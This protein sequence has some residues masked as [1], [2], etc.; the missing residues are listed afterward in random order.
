MKNI[1]T[2]CIALFI[3]AGSLYAQSSKTELISKKWVINQEAMRP[4]IAEI[5]K[6]D[7]ETASLTGEAR[8]SAIS[9]GVKRLAKMRIE[10][11]TD[12]SAIM[13]SSKGEDKG[14]WRFN[15][16]E[17]ELYTKRKGSKERKFTIKSLSEDQLVIVSSNNIKL[18][19]KSS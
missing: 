13:A 9:E 10:M 8:E 17:T 18:I 7:P 2:I 16:K 12:G 11:N 6:L 15:K 4:V 3:C 5:L 1:M 19:L 14:T